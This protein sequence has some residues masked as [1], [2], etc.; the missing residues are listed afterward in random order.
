MESVKKHPA[1]KQ[2][3]DKIL[4]KFDREGYG[5]L[6][7]DDEF[8]EWMSIDVSG[9][10]TIDDFKHFNTLMLDRYEAT[11]RLLDDHDLCLMRIPG[12][13]GFEIL[14]PQD[15]ITRGYDKRIGKVRK[16]INH[17]MKVVTNVNHQV[18][19]IE[20]ERDRQLKIIKTGLVKSAMN[21]RKLV[22][23]NKEQLKLVGESK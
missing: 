21:K 7:T 18:L 15:Q 3:I 10:K 22:I 2:A 8:M 9:L 17:L 20:E 16:E 4:E 19:S 6:I 14:S 11:R 1:W 5:C 12:I 23:E 13:R